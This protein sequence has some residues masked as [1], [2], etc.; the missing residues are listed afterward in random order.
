MAG[1]P[2]K[3]LVIDDD[4]MLLEMEEQALS[5][6]GD[7]EIKTCN[8]Y[9]EALSSVNGFVPDLILLDLRMPGKD[10]TETIS[11]LKAVP[12]ISK[13]PVIFVT[14]EHRVTMQD[15]YKELDVIGVIHKPFKPS[16]FIMSIQRLWQ[17]Y[18][19]A[20]DE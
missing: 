20:P 5:R 9:E 10:G 7:I 13:T 12:Q 4:P 11:D 16:D 3:V 17:A 19:F 8:G 14:G 2:E 1:F 6:A 15:E 18:R